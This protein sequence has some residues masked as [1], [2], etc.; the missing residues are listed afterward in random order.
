M[1]KMRYSI[2]EKQV[3]ALI[4]NIVEGKIAIPEIQRPFV[5]DA[6]DVRDFLDSLSKGWP[7]GYL[8]TSQN[9]EVRSKDGTSSKGK[10]MIIDGQQRI[11]AIMA[12]LL[13]QEVIDKDYKTRQI[14]ISFHPS[15]NE[16]QVSNPIK[17]TSD[18]GWIEDI[19]VIFN[20][21]TN[22]SSLEEN[23]CKHN[24][25]TNKEE[26]RRSIDS[27]KDIENNQ[28]GIIELDS[29]LDI[30]AIAEIFIRVNSKGVQ[31]NQ[32]DFAISK[33]AVNE[34][35]GGNILRKAIDYFCHLAVTPEF[36]SDLKKDTEFVESEFFQKMSWLH[37]KS[38]D[39][40]DPSYTD[41]LRVA[42]TTEFKRGHLKD[43]VALLSGRNFETKQ[44]EETIVEDTFR[45]LKCSINRFMKE[46]YF[47]QFIIAIQS[48]GF[49]TASMISSQN[50][51][52]FAYIIYLAM[53][54][55]K[56]DDADIQRYVRR[57]FVMSLLTG[58]YS[59]S[60]E[61]KF[62][63]D[64]RKIHELGIEKYFGGLCQ[65]A[66][67][68]VFWDIGLPN[69]ME[70]SANSSPY[71][72]LYRAAQIKMNEK[73]FLSD[74][75]VEHLVKIQ[76]DVHHLFPRGYLKNKGKNQSEYNQIANYV[77]CEKPINVAIDNKEPKK[78]FREI[79]EQCNGGTKK[80]GNITNMDK[81]RE[82]FLMNCIHEDCISEN[83][84]EH[85][86]VDNYSNF[87]AGRRRLMAR[88][89]KEYFMA[90]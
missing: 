23:Y 17:Y 50:A 1:I 89:I 24:P 16:L 67:S 59:G 33:I 74:S 34:I 42:F 61:S 72:Q 49:V 60:P 54:D 82:N 35:Y 10:M 19:S 51:L 30:D 7:V 46:Y 2:N 80:Y 47:N 48:A 87:L 37:E 75:T 31:L 81:L 62:D 71:F 5:W 43:L 15:T 70:T 3:G 52:N 63:E 84:I 86:T 39:I 13:G 20:P 8:I 58:R 12:S 53:R 85:M 22:R 57:W 88:K 26:L 4:Y 79:L 25:G 45:R 27:L 36:Y 56:W 21:T 41:M 69:A 66:L 73:G 18:N 78:Y 28:I 9:P 65:S 64:I 32:A 55:Q 68:D 6:T 76:S 90:L 11:I 77:V 14:R 40:Y 44:Y 38:F 83:G 29:D